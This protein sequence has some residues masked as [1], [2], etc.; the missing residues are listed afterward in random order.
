VNQTLAILKY[1][2]EKLNGIIQVLDGHEQNYTLKFISKETK[3]VLINDLSST[4]SYIN[5]V[6]LA[7]VKDLK[8][9]KRE[10]IND[11]KL[12]EILDFAMRTEGYYSLHEAKED[13]VQYI[14]FD[15]GEID[16]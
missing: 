8:K 10:K 11:D 2:V 3:N 14:D 4:I 9:L 12:D 1:Q 15:D 13:S 16:K 5:D 7:Y 6:T